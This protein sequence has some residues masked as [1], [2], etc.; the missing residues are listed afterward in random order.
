MGKNPDEPAM[1]TAMV[2][3]ATGLIGKELLGQ[4]AASDDYSRVI[5]LTRRPVTSDNPNITYVVTNFENLENSLAAYTPDD[6]FC[7]LGTTLAKAGSKE[8]FFRVDYTYPVALAHTT[9]ALGATQYLLVS[10]L[11]A[12]KN[13]SIYYNRVKGQVEDSVKAMRFR[14]IHILR[15]SLLLGRRDEKRSAEDTAKLLYRLFGFIIPDKYKAIEARTVARAML[16]YASVDRAGVFV[17]ESKEIQKF[18]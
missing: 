9:L 3:G 8:K 7:C 10:A 17:H 18:K 4:L 16:Q 14:S 5:A 15:P 11:G 6:V 2:A 13:S 12:E 1:K